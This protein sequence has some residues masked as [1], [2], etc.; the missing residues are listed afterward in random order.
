MTKP[1]SSTPTT[2]GE[3][4]VLGPADVGAAPIAPAAPA[5]PRR[6]RAMDPIVAVLTAGPMASMSLDRA[7]QE[8]GNPNPDQAAEDAL[9][10]LVAADDRLLVTEGRRI[11]LAATVPERPATW[12]KA[13]PND[14][15]PAGDDAPP[16]IEEDPAAVEPP[17][18]APDH[19]A[20]APAE[21]APAAGELLTIEALRSVIDDIGDE[22]GDPGDGLGTKLVAS[23]GDVVQELRVRGFEASRELVQRVAIAGTGVE[24]S[25]ADEPGYDDTV[26]ID[27]NAEPEVIAG[28]GAAPEA[29]PA[30]DAP[31]AGKTVMQVV[32]ETQVVKGAA[33]LAAMTP[34]ERQAALLAA[35]QKRLELMA[36][37]ARQHAALG[38]EAGSL[39]SALNEVRER[40]KET[41]KQLAELAR[42]PIEEGIQMRIPGIAPETAAPATAAEKPADPTPST[43]ERLA[44]RLF[45]E[46][47]AAARE[48]KTEGDCPVVSGD[49]A[50]WLDG[51]RDATR[52]EQVTVPAIKLGITEEK[53]E[54]HLLP[55]GGMLPIGEKPPAVVTVDAYDRPHFVIGLL[56]GATQGD[57]EDGGYPHIPAWQAQWHLQPLY[58]KDE[59]Q[60]LFEE[61]FGRAVKGFDQGDEAQAA[62]QLGGI[63]C[64]RVVKVGRKEWVVGP[65]SQLLVL[66]TGEEP[67]A[68]APTDDEPPRP[69]GKDAAAGD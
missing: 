17:S 37:L 32:S 29:S 69:T 30:A 26:S 35:H 1:K 60:Q 11:A 24:Y 46:G 44:V 10:R 57:A 28:P 22:H 53:L 13:D 62:R 64:G 50:H 15:P 45:A 54:Q 51:W 23:V 52:K 55:N 63:D 27:P 58:S 49:R 40:Q 3:P 8:V 42:T 12:T 39:Q 67:A 48:G 31:A 4:P 14:E 18:A 61:Q 68:S 47:A 25:R 36:S 9:L 65:R 38:S 6:E 56:P 59:W 19:A 41:A 16:A 7:L 2:A 5:K 43:D 34:E 66:T 21:Q 20:A 33:A